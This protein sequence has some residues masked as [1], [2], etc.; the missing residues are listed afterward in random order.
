M[1]YMYDIVIIKKQINGLSFWLI[2]SVYTRKKYIK[3]VKRGGI[4]GNEAKLFAVDFEKVINVRP[5]Y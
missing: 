5:L 4:T 1:V 3:K 2:N